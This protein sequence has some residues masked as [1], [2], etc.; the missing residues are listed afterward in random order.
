MSSAP[1]GNSRAGPHSF[2]DR[3][4]RRNR[5]QYNNRNVN[6]GV[7]GQGE[8]QQGSG[9]ATTRVQAGQVNGNRQ[10]QGDGALTTG[11]EDQGVRLQGPRNATTRME[12]NGGNRPQQGNRNP[13]AVME[14]QGVRQQGNR[15]ST[16]SAKARGNQQQ[17]QQQQGVN[18]TPSA[19]PQ[20]RRNSHQQHQPQTTVS[21]AQGNQQQQQHVNPTPGTK[22]QQRRNSYQQQQQPQTTVSGAQGNQQQQQHVNPTSSTKP[23]QRRNSHQQQQPPQTTVSG[24]QGNQQQQQHVNQTLSTNPQQRRNS[25]QQQHQPQTPTAVAQGNRQNNRLQRHNHSHNHHQTQPPPAPAPAPV[26]HA[27]ANS[28]YDA[29]PYDASLIDTDEEVLPVH[30]FENEILRQVKNH[31]VTIIRGETG[32]GKS[33]VVPRILLQDHSGLGPPVE[34]DEDGSVVKAPNNKGR[35]GRRPQPFPRKPP[36]I[37]CA[38]PRRVAAIKLAERV[39]EQLEAA[40]AKFYEHDHHHYHQHHQ[41]HHRR[42]RAGYRIMNDLND[43]NA[44]IVF[45]TTGYL[46]QWFSKNNKALQSAT[47]IVLD[48]AHERTVEM[49]LLA[50]LIRRKMWEPDM[51][52]KLIVMSATLDIDLY[53]AYFSLPPPISPL[54]DP[55]PPPTTS[56]QDHLSSPITIHGRQFP[57]TQVFLEDL[58]NNPITKDAFPIHNVGKGVIDPGFVN[59]YVNVGASIQRKVGLFKGAKVPNRARGIQSLPPQ[60]DDP[61]YALGVGLCL[62]LSGLTRT[63]GKPSHIR[64]TDL[65][66]KKEDTSADAHPDDHGDDL[67]TEMDDQNRGYCILVFLPGEYEILTWTETLSEWVGW[68]E[69]EDNSSE[70]IN[71]QPLLGRSRSLRSR[72]QIHV[73][74]SQTPKQD[75]QNAFVPVRKG[76]CKIVLA[77]NIAESS[78]TIPDVDCVIDYGLRRAIEF[79]AQRGMQQLSLGWISRASSKQR[80]GRTGRCAPGLFIPFYTKTFLQTCCLEHEPAEIAQKSLEGVVLQVKDLFPNE[81]ARVLFGEMVEPPELDQLECAFDNLRRGGALIRR[82]ARESQQDGS[83]DDG[84]VDDEGEDDEG[85]VTFLGRV[86]PKFPVELVQVRLI[87]LG[88]ASNCACESIVLAAALSAQDVYTMPHPLLIQDRSDLQMK[89]AASFAGRWETNAGSTLQS[90]PLALLN[91]FVWWALQPNRRAR[92]DYLMKTAIHYGRWRHFRSLVSTLALRMAEVLGEHVETTLFERNQKQE[93]KQQQ[94]QRR[95]RQNRGGRRNQ[96]LNDPEIGDEFAVARETIKNLYLLSEFALMKVGIRERHDDEDRGATTATAAREVED[97]DDVRHIVARLFKADVDALRSILLVACA[98]NILVGEPATDPLQDQSAINPKNRRPPSAMQNITRLN[99]WLEGAKSL[100]E[101][102]E[103]K[104]RSKREKAAKKKAKKAAKK[105]KEEEEE[106]SKLDQILGVTSASVGKGD[107]A[108]IGGLV[109]AASSSS[110]ASASSNWQAMTADP[111]YGLRSQDSSSNASLPLWSST[112]LPQKSE[113]SRLSLFRRFIAPGSTED[114]SAPTAERIIPGLPTTTT[115]SSSTSA[116]GTRKSPLYKLHSRM[117][118]LS[119]SLSRWTEDESFN[120]ALYDPLDPRRCAIIRFRHDCPPEYLEPETLR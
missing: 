90:E 66:G 94:Q 50:M 59:N 120:M 35:Q 1:H 71:R 39:D 106:R 41:V 84:A 118:S 109:R 76:V 89:L 22:P 104:E 52:F 36:R 17:Q 86:A 32:C 119:L 92:D 26:S 2:I 68:E 43:H 4:D 53:N 51:N 29:S 77:T 31:R 16:P 101:E 5:P 87:L 42:F 117:I 6:Q 33:T 107:K 25:H 10:Q 82:K 55:T 47:H 9:N 105:K 97:D 102:E 3:L 73:L 58:L 38:Q 91:A 103:K 99:Q 60:I 61:T 79:N 81:K 113:D 34:D 13:T 14:S 18:P 19:K 85:K 70:D 75:V 116:A 8:R 112:S 100:V 44:Q 20:Q 98:P 57:I 56:L 64:G 63:D 45:A 15:T 27:A 78:V 37:I 74:H 65:S 111:Y 40:A 83:K 11:V 67:G 93:E 69:D 23:Q 12:A 28:R 46:L 114:T 49:D 24:A 48:E 95:G 21:G 62:Y 108:P 80:M 96:H 54:K 88:M 110:A 30:E 115:S 7:K 72:V